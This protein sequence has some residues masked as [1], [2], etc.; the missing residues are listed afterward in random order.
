MT[1]YRQTVLT[2][3]SHLEEGPER[4]VC[5]DDWARSSVLL[6]QVDWRGAVIWHAGGSLKADTCSEGSGGI[7]S[8][9]NEALWDGWWAREGRR[10]SFSF[11]ILHTHTHRPGSD[12]APLS[13]MWSLYDV[14]RLS[15]GSDELQ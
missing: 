13:K 7:E 15:C 11:F 8:S 6:S 3:F 4:S 5:E 14:L 12:M 1:V 9:V 2:C 10:S